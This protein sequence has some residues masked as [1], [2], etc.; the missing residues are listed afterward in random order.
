MKL[1]YEERKVLKMLVSEARKKRVRILA[2]RERWLNFRIFN[3]WKD[4]MRLLLALL[5]VLLAG[6]VVP[7]A[8]AGFSD[9]GDSPDVC[10]SPACGSSPQW[11]NGFSVGYITRVPPTYY[12]Y[13]CTEGRGAYWQWRWVDFYGYVDGYP[14]VLD[15]PCFYYRFEGY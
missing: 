7:T 5:G 10:Q 3:Y 9:G 4:E 15:C 13:K 1:T 11:C 14:Q 12:R 6:V 8:T 2:A